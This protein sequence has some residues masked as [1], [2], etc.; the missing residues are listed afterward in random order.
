[1]Q[2]TISQ[3]N[4]T[5][6]NVEEN[7]TLV[8]NVISQNPETNVFIFPECMLSGYLPL[9]ALYYDSFFERLN[10]A[11]YRIQQSLGDTQHCVLGTLYKEKHNV[12]NAINSH[13]IQDH[14]MAYNSAIQDYQSCFYSYISHANIYN[15]A[16]Y[17]HKHEIVGIQHK[18]LLPHK[19][20][21]FEQRYFQEGTKNKLFHYNDI[22]FAVLICEDL[23]GPIAPGYPTYDMLQ[24]QPDI[25]IVISASP[26]EIEKKDKRIALAKMLSQKNESPLIF[27]NMVGANDEIIFDGSSFVL[28]KDAQLLH[29][30]LHC[31]QDNMNVYFFQDKNNNKIIST[32]KDI[33]DLP[34][35]VRN[36]IAKNSHLATSYEQIFISKTSLLQNIEEIVDALCMGLID[37]LDKSSLPRKVH[38]GISGGIDSAVVATLACRSIGASN[39][40]GI[41][42]PSQYTSKESW[43]D[44]LALIETLGMPHYILSIED[45]YATMID[46]LAPIFQNTDL[47]STEE[48]LQARIRGI[49]LM[50]Y[51][52]KH[53]SV[54]LTTGNK[55]ELAVGYATLYG[56]MCGAI[57]I[58]GDLY[59]TQVYEVAKY[60]NNETTIIP[61]RIL[62]KAPSAE[63]RKNQRDDDSL[64]PYDILDELLYL[65]INEYKSLEYVL[66]LSK[67]EEHM[68]KKVWKL[69][70]TS[71]F[72]RYQAP[73][74]LKVSSCA[75]G[76]GRFV[77]LVAQF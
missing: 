30:L 20:I 61:Q 72:K 28:T 17:F 38:L 75:F 32:Q 25:I 52:N 29:Q 39:V 67:Y 6:G 14:S 5:I 36:D 71:E 46:I 31:K 37:F 10:S 18:R 1:M 8:M 49:L 55:S 62:E 57:N 34:C 76:R 74:I 19:D 48:N 73:P 21:F 53:S 64:P 22:S 41:L 13:S 9:D 77:P 54:L 66:S 27:C 4:P 11:M 40:C 50:G 12:N 45:A 69:Y 60:L 15:S 42:L 65:F 3:L 43:D 70:Q 59:K 26:Y 24:L 56:D 23:W 33:H 35:S 68:V 2:F 51:A 16:F 47:D 44:A 63:L 7:T 58:I